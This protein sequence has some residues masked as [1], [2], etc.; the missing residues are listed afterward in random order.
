M[1]KA[2]LYEGRPIGEDNYYSVFFED[3]DRIKLEVVYSPG[4]C[5][6]GY[7]TNELKD[8]FDPYEKGQ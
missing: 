6:V 8:D 5:E 4:Y 3:P 2:S 1:V 7:W